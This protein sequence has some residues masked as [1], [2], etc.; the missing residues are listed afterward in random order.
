M[1]VISKFTLFGRFTNS[2]TQGT[3]HHGHACELGSHTLYEYFVP[4]LVQYIKFL[5]YFFMF[6][7][8]FVTFCNPKFL[9]ELN[10]LNRGIKFTHPTT[11][12][13]TDMGLMPVTH[14]VTN[15][16]YFCNLCHKIHNFLNLSESIS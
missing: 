4:S 11:S 1:R 5:F 2:C 9:K 6:C 8:Y 3:N 10:L 7:N 13:S 14:L 16:H 12:S 15:L